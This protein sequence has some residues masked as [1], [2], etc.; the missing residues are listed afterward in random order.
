ME[1]ILYNTILGALPI[2]ADGTSFYY[3]DYSHD[4]QESLLRRQMALLLGDL[5]ATGGRLPH[6][7]VSCVQPM[8]CT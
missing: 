5:P 7:H 6:Q 3:S 1:R 8:A 2:Q 4:R